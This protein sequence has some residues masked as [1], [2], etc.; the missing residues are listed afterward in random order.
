VQRSVD[1]VA[2][3]PDPPAGNGRNGA[4]AEQLSW[5]ADVP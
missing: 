3:S 2:M 4:G 5:L 1:H